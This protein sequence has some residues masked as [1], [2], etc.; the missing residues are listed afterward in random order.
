MASRL[1]IEERVQIILLHAKFENAEE[2]RRQWKN[3]FTTQPPNRETIY[4]LVKKFNDTG[5]VHDQQRSGRP[6][7]ATNEEALLDV[8]LKVP[9]PRQ[10]QQEGGPVNW[11]CQRAVISVLWKS[12]TYTAIAHS[13][14][15]T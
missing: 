10:P 3:H 14:L 9:R 8:A 1:S 13:S 15:L 11:A 6:I 12:S 5:S 2:V 7:T 4:N